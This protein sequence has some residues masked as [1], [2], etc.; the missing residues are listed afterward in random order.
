MWMSSLLRGDWSCGELCE[1]EEA[2]ACESA[3]RMAVERSL[4]PT[5]MMLRILESILHIFG[6]RWNCEYY[7]KAIDHGSAI[8]F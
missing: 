7:D 8:S 1:G 2:L 6:D 4:L 5:T 3:W